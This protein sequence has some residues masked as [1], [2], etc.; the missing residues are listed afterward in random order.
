MTNTDTV[1]T[2]KVCI[3]TGATAGIGLITAQVLAQSG[4]TVVGVGRNPGKNET[5][6]NQIRA[7]TGNANVEFLLAD[8]SVQGDIHR[9]V[10]QFKSKY[11][12][13]DVLVNNAGA[14]FMKRQLTRD[15][16]ELTLALNHLN[17]FLLTHL[18]LNTLKA[19][20]PARI[21]NVASD[22]HRSGKINFDNLQGE[23]KYGG[24]TAYS[25]SKLAN[26]LFTYELGRCL[27]GT[28]IT[29]NSLHPGVVASNF[30][31]NNGWLSRILR[32][33]GDLFSI[34]VEDGAKTNIYLAAS[35]DA[36]GITGKYF[37]EKQREV[38]SSASSYDQDVARRLWEVSEALTGI[39]T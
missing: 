8:L 21:I 19:S 31:A 25:Q 6:A 24:M 14:L 17:Y 39:K 10:E 4:A 27:K 15:N 22:A 3:V 29:A 34:S 12:R 32:K 38:R 30:G 2:G 13:L 11:Q 26:I 16:L 35:P 28:N 20:A 18:L 37:D 9:L 33:V 23:K 1:M 36:E 5:T 7:Q